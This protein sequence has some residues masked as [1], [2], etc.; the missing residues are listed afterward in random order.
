MAFV[1]EALMQNDFKI[2]YS[3][4]CQC[5][6]DHRIIFKPIFVTFQCTDTNLIQ[7]LFLDLFLDNF[8]YPQKFAVF[9]QEF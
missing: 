7:G 8:F 9:S 3:L 4:G 6:F 5:F 2:I 1:L